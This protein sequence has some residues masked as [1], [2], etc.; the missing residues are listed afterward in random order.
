MSDRGVLGRVAPFAGAAMIALAL[1]LIPPASSNL[2]M[3]AAAATVTAILTLATLLVPW[4]RLPSWCQA[5]VPLSFFAVIALLRQA[6]GGAT[7]GYS[8]LVM[9]P[10][11][12]LALYGNRTQLRLAIAATAATF[13]AP[14]ILVGPPLYPIAGWRESATWIVIG[15][16]GGS[17]TQSLVEQARHRTA[18]VA[19][20]GSITR[21]LTA[22]LD[23]R[24]ELCA[25]AQ[26]VTGAAL[27]ILYEPHADGDLVATA[28]TDGAVFGPMRIDP[29]VKA[30]RTAEA[31]H[32]GTRVYIADVAADPRAPGQLVKDAGAEALLF[33]PVT[34]A[35]RRMGVLVM[36]LREARPS[37]PERALFLVELLAAEIGAAIAR[38][39][40]VAQL[41]EQSRSDPLTG[42]ANRLSWDEELERELA[43]TRR[44][45][46]PLT[47]AL[48]DIDHFKAYNDAH[49]HVAGDVLLKDF[50]TA[51]RGELRT[52]DIIARWG[53]EEFTLALPDCDIQ[54]A[55]TIAL[56]LLNVVP[57]G[58]TA[59]IGL[60]TAGTNDTP[61]TLI[62]RADRALYTAK[63]GGRNQVKAFPARTPLGPAHGHGG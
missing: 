53:G 25:A 17:A 11:L 62:E 20:L 4:V 41:A 21:A 8:S 51:I 55:Q 57:N 36:G 35:G 30:S 56:R 33:E 7:S 39:E 59:S 19:A 60:T 29:R 14:L 18:D 38:A 13:L 28:S 45:A 23:P 61:R 32:T 3:L 54:Q 1:E 26:L 58:Q 42:A 44:T 34:Q 48:I 49:G 50:V 5:I 22:G 31:W 6:G 2:S 43:R 63:N 24:P 15:L 52:G 40:L 27:A 46:V 12:W 10:I 47:I 37:V 9:L 16:L